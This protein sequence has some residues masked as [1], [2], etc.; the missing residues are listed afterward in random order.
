MSI[1]AVATGPT[2]WLWVCFTVEG[3]F[4]VN[5]RHLYLPTLAFHVCCI[6]QVQSA[7]T[8]YRMFPTVKSVLNPTH[9]QPI[10]LMLGSG[11]MSGRHQLGDKA[12]QQ[13]QPPFY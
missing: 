7:A 4:Y 12:P 2:I 11:V 1:L 10:C 13:T 3:Q 9:M 6:P 8:E 5:H